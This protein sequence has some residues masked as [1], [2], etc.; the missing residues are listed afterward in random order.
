MKRSVLFFLLLSG[1]VLLGCGMNRNNLGPPL[2]SWEIYRGVIPGY[3]VEIDETFGGYRGH[4]L[5]RSVRL[6]PQDKPDCTWCAISGDDYDAD[7]AWERMSYCGYPQ[8]ND[9]CNAVIF[10]K[11]GRKWDPAPA[12]RGIMQPFSDQEVRF[13]ISRLNEAIR[14]VRNNEHLVDTL[15]TF[16]KRVQ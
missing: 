6:Q 15:E 5:V 4:T 2:L 3:W 11:A 14:T 12:Y 13:A 9:G 16:Q 10:T 7:N 8:V 1:Y